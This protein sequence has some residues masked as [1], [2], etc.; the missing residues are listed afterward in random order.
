MKITLAY[1]SVAVNLI[2]SSVSAFSVSP[3][4]S[5]VTRRSTNMLMSKSNE[6]SLEAEVDMLL[7]KEK[8][9]A[10]KLGKISSETGNKQFAPWM[11]FTEEDERKLRGILREKAIAARKQR[12]S[13]RDSTNQELSGTGLQYKVVNGNE[14]ELEWATGSEKNT[15]GFILKRR[16][17][18]TEN[19]DVLADYKSYGPL[20]SKGADGGM[21]RYIDQDVAPGGYV[22]R[23][24]EVEK[25]GSENDLSQCLVDIQT[26]SEQKLQVVA[27]A[28]FA[29]VAAAALAA[30]ILLDPIQ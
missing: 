14:V 21:Y 17:A 16:A 18:K 30:G 19:F 2:A 13:M 27:L 6:K 9:K 10:A 23:V 3:A 25:N 11:S 7:Q 15:K 29:L 26:E 22:Y 12:S 5:T 28:G 24:T 8:E 1:I 20:A 4:L